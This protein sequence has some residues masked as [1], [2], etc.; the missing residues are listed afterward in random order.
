MIGIVFWIVAASAMHFIGPKVF[1]GSEVHALFW[2]ANFGLP[3]LVIPMFAKMTGRTKHDMLAP[4]ALIA[5]PAMLLDGLAVTFDTMGKTHIYADTAL[6]SAYTGGFLLFA[7]M[8]F[9]FW[10]LVWHED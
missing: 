9:F 10:A 4:T 5:L 2:V 8:S 3:V 6:L 1:D 7:F